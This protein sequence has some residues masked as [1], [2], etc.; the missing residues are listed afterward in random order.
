MARSFGSLSL[1]D[2]VR[3]GHPIKILLDLVPE[4]L[5]TALSDWSQMQG[6]ELCSVDLRD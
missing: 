1:Q 2:G 5:K 3:L 6:W 4:E